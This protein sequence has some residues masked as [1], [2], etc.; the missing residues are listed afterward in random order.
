M[1]GT[2]TKSSA[3]DTLATAAYKTSTKNKNF[4]LQNVSFKN[5][6]K[7]LKKTVQGAIQAGRFFDVS[8]PL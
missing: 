7:L 3:Q 2:Y 5:L 1:T 4:S 8:G 6:M